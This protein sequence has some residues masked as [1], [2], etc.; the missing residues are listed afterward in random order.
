MEASG[1]SFL[2]PNV[3][4]V[5]ISDTAGRGYKAKANI[6]KGSLILSCSAYSKLLYTEVNKLLQ[7][8]TSY[9]I[10]ILASGL[11]VERILQKA[12]NDTKNKEAISQLFPQDNQIEEVYSKLNTSQKEYVDQIISRVKE[13]NP[14]ATD[15]DI[16]R[17]TEITLLNP[18]MIDLESGITIGLGLYPEASFFNHSCAPNCV[19]STILNGDYIFVRAIRDIKAGEEI[20]HSYIDLYLTCRERRQQLE[21][22]LFDC[23]C[24]RCSSLPFLK[25]DEA[26]NAFICPNGSKCPNG[27][28][29]PQ[30]DSKN[31]KCSTC[32]IEKNFDEYIKP[33][34]EV[35]L[36]FFKNGQQHK[37]SGQYEEAK[38]DFDSLIK[39]SEKFQLLHPLHSLLFKSYICQ[40]PIIDSLLL[41]HAEQLKNESELT[42][43]AKQKYVEALVLLTKD[44][45]TY[46]KKA[47]VCATC[48]F[49]PN[50]PEIAGIL[51]AQYKSLRQLSEFTTDKR[52]LEVL[53]KEARTVSE[54]AK[55]IYRLSRGGDEEIQLL[56]EYEAKKAEAEKKENGEVEGTKA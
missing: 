18:H 29:V 38:K 47:T 23:Q 25:R 54:K 20:C 41:A 28:L 3:E 6:P 8:D 51:R 1:G 22:Y 44:M 15:S 9:P 37:S 27:R 12:L 40:I 53:Q 7:G 45:H 2:N 49:P 13:R 48:I 17:I 31:W 21:N 14:T 43:E 26:L 55:A 52:Q 46:A 5:T 30:Q 50:L 34:L 24:E 11:L 4:L 33:N 16:K 56:K 35:I 32:G 10:Q 36:Q 39:Y 19:Y 42:T